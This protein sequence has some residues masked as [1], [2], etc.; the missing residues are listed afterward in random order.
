ML[1]DY[2]QTQD[3]DVTIFRLTGRLALGRESDRVESILDEIGSEQHTRVI[4]DF[5]GV[6]YIDS[7][8]VALVTA[9]AT[10]MQGRGGKLLAVAPAGSRASRVFH[11]TQINLVVPLFETLEAARAAV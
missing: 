3:Q 11:L 6:T 8:G 7:G 4:V 10:R 9:A 2:Q 5:T 1:L